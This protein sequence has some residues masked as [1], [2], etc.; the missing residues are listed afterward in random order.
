MNKLTKRRLT[1]FYCELRW[2][3]PLLR[4]HER[5]IDEVSRMY[6]TLD[7]FMVKLGTMNESGTQ[8]HVSAILIDASHPRVRVAEL[9]P[10]HRSNPLPWFLKLVRLVE[11]LES[12]TLYGALKRLR[13]GEIENPDS[14]ALE[15]ANWVVILHECELPGQWWFIAKCT[16]SV[17][18][19]KVRT[20]DQLSA[21][22][23]FYDQSRWAETQM[24]VPHSTWGV[25]P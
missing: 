25:A 2:L 1:T 20:N 19:L 24:R 18:I 3:R 22:M 10:H 9:T 16:V 12:W 21:L 6:F 14:V 8:S 13:M 15:R 4:P 23:A 11:P 5:W 7:D 17:T